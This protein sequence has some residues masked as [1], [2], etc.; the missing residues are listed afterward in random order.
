MG[1]VNIT[2]DSFSDGGRFYKPDAAFKQ[3]LRLFENGAD[4]IDLGA[5]SSRPGAGSLNAADEWARLEPVLKRLSS[6]NLPLF[7]SVD[8]YKPEI[9]RR[10]VDHGAQI[11]NDIKGGAD[12]STLEYLASQSATYLAMHMHLSPETMQQDPLMGSSAVA[13][14]GLF[15]ENTTKFLMDCGFDKKNIWL[16][17]GIGF[18]KDDKANLLLLEQ[19]YRLTSQFQIA[20]G[21]SRKSF[22][23]RLLNIDRPQDRD[24]ATKMLEF[25]FLAHNIKAIRT[26]EVQSLAKMRG[27]LEV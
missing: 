11:V 6:E 7:I 2:P 10:A 18:G 1:V 26:H 17:P 24:P 4:I 14:V 22:I 27:L 13:D 23:G 8:T 3:A 9:M 20:L 19:T 25:S 16:D 5:E 15:Y 21:V 12:R